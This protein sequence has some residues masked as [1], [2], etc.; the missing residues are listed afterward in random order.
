LTDEHVQLARSV[1]ALLADSAGKR[2]LS[3]DWS[4]LPLGLDR[5]LWTSLAGLDLVGLAVP[6]GLGGPGAG[7]VEECVVAEE[8]GYALPAVPFAASTVVTAL[9]AQTGQAFL[10]GISGGTVIAGVAWETFPAPIVPRGRERALSWNGGRV[11]GTLGAVPFGLDT[12]LL[13]VAG[14]GSTALVDLRGAGVSRA[15]VDSLDLTEPLAVIT[16]QDVPAIGLGSAAPVARILTILAAE[17]VGTG[18]RA[19]D[20]AVEYARQRHQFGRA[21]GSFQAIKHTL[22]DRYVELDAARLLVRGATGPGQALVA[23]AA[24][25]EAAENAAGDALQTHGG[26]GFTWENSSHVLLRRVRA[27]RSLLGSRAQRLDTVAD[28]LLSAAGS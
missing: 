21:I 7:I 28:R 11:S 9:L 22:A 13:L 15:S 19:L 3:P 6:E 26:M 8:I 1:A 4:T 24:A 17:L 5:H 25:L 10:A 18:R 20:D 16:L 12:D 14:Q 27:R 23:I 2:S